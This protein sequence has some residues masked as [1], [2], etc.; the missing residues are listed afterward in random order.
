MICADHDAEGSPA[1]KSLE[2]FVTLPQ[3]KGRTVLVEKPEGAGPQ[4]VKAFFPDVTAYQGYY[5][6]KNIGKIKK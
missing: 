5:R 4:A 3:E 2:T 6:K 1:A